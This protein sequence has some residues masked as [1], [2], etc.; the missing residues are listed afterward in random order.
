MIRA[1]STDE[2]SA[3][4][5]AASCSGRRS[6]T[7][8][9]R[10]RKGNRTPMREAQNEPEDKRCQSSRATLARTRSGWMPLSRS[11]DSRYLPVW[12]SQPCSPGRFAGGKLE[13][14]DEGTGVER[15]PISPEPVSVSRKSDELGTVHQV[16]ERLLQQLIGPALGQITH[17]D[18][19]RPGMRRT[20]RGAASQLQPIYV[21][22]G[23]PRRERSDQA[24]AR[25]P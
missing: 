14:C 12:T 23:R 24:I 20:A 2:V 22:Q 16:I 1:E 9:D 18:S 4:L 7:S 10:C 11:T 3:G 17:Q 25:L 15:Q 13:G 6:T 5:W 19:L 8:G 21:R